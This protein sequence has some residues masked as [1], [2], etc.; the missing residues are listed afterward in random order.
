MRDV[1]VQMLVFPRFRG[2]DRSFTRMSAGIFGP[3]LDTEYDWAKVPPYNGNDPPPAPGSL[4]ALLFPPLLNNVENKRTQGVRT[5][6]GAEIPPFISIVRYP[7]RPI[8]FVMEKLPL[9]A[10]FSLLQHSMKSPQTYLRD[11]GANSG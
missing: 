11:F 9:W 7:G 5:R 1:R 8:I 2:P 3:K 10:E 6:Y 4:K